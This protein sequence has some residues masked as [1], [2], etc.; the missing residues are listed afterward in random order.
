MNVGVKVDTSDCHRAT[1]AA[2]RSIE[3]TIPRGVDKILKRAAAGERSGHAYTNRT[4]NLE[5][6]TIGG[7]DPSPGGFEGTLEAGE[8][9]ASYVNAKGLMKIDQQAAKATV[10]IEALIVAESD[11]ISDV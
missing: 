3:G 10:E 11:A 6:H 1:R 4:G 5:L 9:Y 2:E 7:A 8:E